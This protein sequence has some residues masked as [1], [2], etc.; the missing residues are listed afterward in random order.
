MRALVLL[1]AA[2]FAICGEVNW[3]SLSDAK[4]LA[5]KENRVI[6][7]EVSAHGCKYCIEMANTTLKNDKITTKL[8]KQFAPV[9]FYNDEGNVPEAFFAKGTPTFFFIDKNGK[10]LGAPIFGAWNANDFEYFL[11]LMLKKAKE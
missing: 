11:D 5:K 8:N 2:T 9:L 10:K 7:V 4:T 3:L 1:F 6:M